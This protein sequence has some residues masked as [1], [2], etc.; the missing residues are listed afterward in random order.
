[1]ISDLMEAFPI[2]ILDRIEVIE[3]PGSVLYG[4]NAFSGVVNL[5]TRKAPRYGI[6]SG[7]NGRPGQP[8]CGTADALLKH[9]DLEI[10]GA[11]QFHQSP[12]WQVDYRTPQSLVSGARP[13]ARREEH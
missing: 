5:I 12:E 8:V 6:P 4:S 3:G 7:G 9:G 10:T 2:A 13:T 11:A 1:M